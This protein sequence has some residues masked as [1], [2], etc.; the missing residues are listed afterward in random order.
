VA[1]FDQRWDGHNDRSFLGICL[2]ASE[3]LITF[4]LKRRRDEKKYE[5]VEVSILGQLPAISITSMRATRDKVWDAIIVK[6]DG[7]LSLLTH[8]LR[9]LPLQ[10]EGRGDRH[11]LMDIDGGAVSGRKII[12]VEDVIFS[13][14][15]I[16]YDDGSKMRTSIDVIPSDITISQAFQVLAQTLPAQ[17]CFSLHRAFLQIWSSRHFSMSDG[18]EF[19]CFEAALAQVFNLGDV[20]VQPAP[21]RDLSHAWQALSHASSHDRFSADPA[22]AR[23]KL[24]SRTKTSKPSKHTSKPHQMLAP[25]LYALHTMGEDM[26]LAPHRYEDL[27]RLASLICRVALVIRPEWADYWKR[28]C[29]DA[30]KGWSSPVTTGEWNF[31]GASTVQA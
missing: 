21:A 1:L 27:L 14:I 12:A 8:G 29:P 7:R 2:P 28:L 20:I 24:P 4:A 11:D 15:T 18:V 9:E 30:M 16:V 31:R 17:Y 26:R 3:T 5:T 19:T 23:L 25:V 22:L 6:P 10:P 13:S